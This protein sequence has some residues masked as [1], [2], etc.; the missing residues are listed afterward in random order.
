MFELFIAKRY[1][2]AKRKQVMISVIT[3]ISVIGVAAG[4]MALVIALAVNNGMRSTLE[5]NFLGLTAH[6]SIQQREGRE[7]IANWQ[8]IAAKLRTLPHVK[9]AVPALYDAGALSGPRNSAGVT[10]KGISVEPDTPIPFT[11][12]HLKKGSFQGLRDRGQP[13][14]VILGTRL[15]DM[16]GGFVG[17]QV[18]LTSPYGKLTPLGARPTF[19]DLRVVGIFESGVYEID[20]LFAFMTLEDVQRMFD[21]GDI[22]NAIELN[23]DD[24]YAAPE[25]AKEAEAVIGPDLHAVTWEESNSTIREAFHMERIVTGITIGLILVVAAMN[26]L[27]TLVMMVMEKHRD[28]AVLMSMGARAAQIRRIFLLKGLIIGG[29]GTGI[30]LILGYTIS[31]FAN[32]YQWIPLS[33]EVYSFSYVPFE[34][35]WLD[36]IWIAA[37]ALAVSVIATLYPAR[38]A[39][40]IEPVESMRYE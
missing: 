29:L 24:I 1:L 27:I 31:Y 23:L 5:R 6:V 32:R 21:W 17:Q 39:T 19:E 10:I 13:P 14:P 33:A 30:G 7:G 9:S 38:S 26:I 18:R 20:S 3:V 37:V 34:P 25:V 35:Q 16:V 40:R 36:G 15:A 28:I 4:V 12:E 2:R 22:V 11:L 8:G